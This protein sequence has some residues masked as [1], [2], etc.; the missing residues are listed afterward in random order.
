MTVR[1]LQDMLT[2]PHLQQTGFFKREQHP[3]EG[4]IFGMAP[5]VRFEITNPALQPAPL[6]GEHS[7]E[8]RRELEGQVETRAHLPFGCAK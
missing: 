5:P 2:D 6:L 1:D 4:P 3:T 8:I 7:E